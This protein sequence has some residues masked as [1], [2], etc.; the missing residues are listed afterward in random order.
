MALPEPTERR[1]ITDTLAAYSSLISNYNGGGFTVEP[2]G[3][4]QS[5]PPQ[6]AAK[7]HSLASP[8][9]DLKP[10]IF[11][12]Y[13]QKD[14]VDRVSVALLIN[15][16]DINFGETYIASDAYTREGWLSTLWGRNQM[17]INANCST[18]AFYVGGFGVSTFLRNFSVAFKNFVSFLGIFKNGGYYYYRGQRN[19]DLFDSDPGRVIGVMDQTKIAY[20]NTEYLGSFNSLTVDESQEAPYRIIFNFEFIVSGLRGE[21]AEGH[22]MHCS[23]LGCNNLTDVKLATQGSYGYED[24]ISIDRRSLS[25]AFA[26]P[27][28]ASYDDTYGADYDIYPLIKA[29]TMRRTN[30]LTIEN[31]ELLY[32]D[33][34]VSSDYL[35]GAYT[36]EELR[37][38]YYSDVFQHYDNIKTASEKYGVEPWV[39]AAIAGRESAG[40][41]NAVSPAGALGVMQITP[42][43]GRDLGLTTTDQFF[44]ASLNIDAGTRYFN[45][46]LN[47]F[48]GD[49]NLALS[50][51]NAGPG[52]VKKYNGIPPYKETVL[53]VYHITNE[54]P[55]YKQEWERI[56][57]EKEQ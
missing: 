2:T 16:S 47:Q 55:W 57:R 3:I 39:I 54:I 20:E 53:Y 9:S 18:A 10:F 34:P 51:Y 5:L 7:P 8:N 31:V 30:D 23:D 15:P 17:T 27:E 45:Q 35:E 38:R 37:L 19:T 40:V 56:T 12:I 49:I 11:S 6:T 1:D 28:P 46:Q 14:D 52:S 21:K 44:D 48:G 41:R 29:S 22:L 32:T 33:L 26:R 43:T 4:V 50:A 24:I 42:R 13:N 36:P 25:E